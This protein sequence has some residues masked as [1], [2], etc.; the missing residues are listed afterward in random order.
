MSGLDNF[1]QNGPKKAKYWYSKGTLKQQII[2]MILKNKMPSDSICLRNS[3]MEDFI[4][5]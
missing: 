2:T 4:L 3:G 1:Q 5:F